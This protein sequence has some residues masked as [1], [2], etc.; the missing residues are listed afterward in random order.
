MGVYRPD[1]EDDSFLKYHMLLRITRRVSNLVSR[2][3]NGAKDF[4]ERSIAGTLELG[5]A[6]KLNLKWLL[7]T[8]VNLA[9]RLDCVKSLLEK[10]IRGESAILDNISEWIK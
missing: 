3:H 7:D 10:D 8:A 1:G 9:E 4:E 2:F 6:G 5:D